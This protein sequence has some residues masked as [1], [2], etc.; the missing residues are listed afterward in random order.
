MSRGA[1]PHLRTNWQPEQ[2]AHVPWLHIVATEV[3]QLTHAEAIVWERLHGLLRKEGGI[4]EGYQ[5]FNQIAAAANCD[6][7]T[8]IRAL[9]KCEN[10]GLVARRHRYRDFGDQAANMWRLLTP[11]SIR[12]EEEHAKVEALK[13]AWEEPQAPQEPLRFQAALQRQEAA[14]RPEPEP[15]EALELVRRFHRKMHGRFVGDSYRPFPAELALAAEILALPDCEEALEWAYT[16]I[17][18]WKPDTLGGLRRYIREYQDLQQRQQLAQQEQEEE[19]ERQEQLAIQRRAVA[20]LCAQRD[21]RLQ[22]LAREEERRRRQMEEEAERRQEEIEI[23]AAAEAARGALA[24]LPGLMGRLVEAEAVFSRLPPADL[25]RDGQP[26]AGRLVA[27]ERM[28]RIILRDELAAMKRQAAH[29]EAD[30]R[31]DLVAPLEVDLELF[32]AQIRLRMP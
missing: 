1:S 18:G 23:A 8:A 15:S 22:E 7:S 20:E 26:M 21:Q 4:W 14:R 32:E 25:G 13:A 31:G 19:A 12:S 11:P 30:Q 5:S 17:K 6:R 16:R 24:D 28:A 29:I 9:R 10:L 27:R 3:R 2:H